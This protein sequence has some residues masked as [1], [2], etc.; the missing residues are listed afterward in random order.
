MK[1]PFTVLLLVALLAA[2]IPTAHASQPDN[3]CTTVNVAPTTNGYTV[4]ATGAG[5]Y[6]RIR[7]LTTSTTVIAT[8]FG[9][10][11]TAYAWTGLALD[12]AHN[13]QVQVSHTSLTTGYSTSGC[14]FTP[15]PPLAVVIAS[16]TGQCVEKGVR[17]EWETV[18]E[19][20]VFSFA[21]S[22]HDAVIATI[23]AQHPGSPI[24]A[25]YVYT[26]TSTGGVYTLAVFDGEP[27]TV[28]VSCAPT[29]V[30]LASFTAA[31]SCQCYVGNRWVAWPCGKVAERACNIWSKG[32]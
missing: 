8:D 1:H 6:A 2:A 14:V 28:T 22:L 25:S 17:L 15:P 11:A 18:S 19:I 13:Y 23:Q 32:R 24:G 4:T 29:S 16:F 5:R 30:E 20:G 9:A 10:G 27:A 31:K 3:Y 21:L 26:D 12:T 7:D